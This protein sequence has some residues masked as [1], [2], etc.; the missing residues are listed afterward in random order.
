[1]GQ[2]Y[3]P[4]LISETGKIQTLYSHDF[5][6]G[7]KLMEHSYIGNEF[8]N[9]A[10]LLL[11][12]KPLK[13]A[14]IGDYSDDPYEDL[15]ANAVSKEKF[16]SYYKAAWRDER[17]KYRVSPSKFAKRQ[18]KTVCTMD[19]AQDHL[20]NHTKRQYIHLGKYISHNKWREE[21]EWQGKPYS[22]DMCVHPL[23]LL[24]ACGNG[25][26][27]GDYHSQYPDYDKVGLWAFDLI[28]LARSIP[29]GYE[30][31]MFGFIEKE[32]EQ[33]APEEPDIPEAI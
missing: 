4:T 27:G 6:H 29:A 32:P 1:M 14:W 3:M 30:E 24:T 21:G 25:R 8:V 31:V 26:G 12:D 5:D 19:S 16:M 13:A 10:L 22:Y 11:Q 23:P 28:E 33:A 17:N 15:Y 9:A 18:L 20:I 2:Y 7:I